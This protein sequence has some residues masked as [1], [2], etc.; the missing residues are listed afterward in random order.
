M[1]D[2]DENVPRQAA[3]EEILEII[4]RRRQMESDPGIGS[5]IERQIQSRGL[6][7]LDACGEPR[8]LEGR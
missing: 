8:S 7:G 1:P 6:G 2:T 5:S 4:Y 3:Y